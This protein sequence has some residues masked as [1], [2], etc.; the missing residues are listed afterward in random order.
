MNNNWNALPIWLRAVFG[1]LFV[2]MIYFGAALAIDRE[3]LVAIV[4]IVGAL[5]LAVTFGPF[6]AVTA[7]TE[8]LSSSQFQALGLSALSGVWV[9]RYVTDDSLSP[10][11]SV[12]I[13]AS[14]AW[15]I[16][17]IL[18]D[19]WSRSSDDE[20]APRAGGRRSFD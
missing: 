16:K 15:L 9:V 8:R 11:L 17:T 13:A 2:L 3:W 4:S 5:W 12:V 19:G 14:A 1:L 20:A 18:T 7:V 10:R 6:S